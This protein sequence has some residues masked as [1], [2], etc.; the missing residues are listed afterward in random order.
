MRRGEVDWADPTASSVGVRSIDRAQSLKAARQGVVQRAVKRRHVAHW[1][2]PVGPP[3][4]SRFGGRPCDLT[5]CSD[6]KCCSTKSWFGL[7]RM[8]DGLHHL[9]VWVR[10]SLGRVRP[11][12]DLSSTRSGMF[13]GGFDHIWVWDRRTSRQFR[14]SSETVRPDPDGWV[15]TMGRQDGSSRA[16]PSPRTLFDSPPYDPSGG[17]QVDDPGPDPRGSRRGPPGPRYSDSP[18]QSAQFDPCS[19]KSAQGAAILT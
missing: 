11:Q 2:P 3:P 7:G 12:R 5:P 6:L 17:E 8:G 15:F 4:P 13:R 14:P 18:H 19:P 16:A 1:R 9:G 10:A